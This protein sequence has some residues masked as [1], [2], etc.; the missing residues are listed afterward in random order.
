MQ[1]S[2]TTIQKYLMIIKPPHCHSAVG[3]VKTE[4]EKTHDTQKTEEG[5]TFLVISEFQRPLPG[6]ITDEGK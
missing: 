4:G 5:H 6:P 2:I 3:Y 1:E